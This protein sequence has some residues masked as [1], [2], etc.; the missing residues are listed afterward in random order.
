[1]GLGVIV[2]AGGLAVMGAYRVDEMVR[3]IRQ[4]GRAEKGDE[5]L[6]NGL[7]K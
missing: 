4:G 3:R 2:A 1:V 5:E 6:R 7:E